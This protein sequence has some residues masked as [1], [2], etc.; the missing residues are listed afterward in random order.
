MRVTNDQM[1]TE[2]KKWIDITDGM[3]KANRNESRK[4]ANMRERKKLGNLNESKK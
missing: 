4:W 1:E 3:K 2:D